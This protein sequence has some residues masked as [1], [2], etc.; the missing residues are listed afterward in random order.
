MWGV[1][2]KWGTEGDGKVPDSIKMSGGDW[3]WAQAGKRRKS[4][5]GL[6]DWR[7]ERSQE[8]HEGAGQWQQQRGREQ[9]KR[10]SMCCL[11]SKALGLEPT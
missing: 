11:E 10:K 5:R 1:Q 3:S 7:R 6:K 9:E 2:T 4:R 8:W